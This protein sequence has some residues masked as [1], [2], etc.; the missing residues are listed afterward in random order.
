[1]SGKPTT[2]VIAADALGIARAAALLRAGG[3]VAIPTETVYGL[4]A[5]ADSAEAVARIYAAKGRPDFNPLIVHVAGLAEAAALADMTP[6]MRAFAESHWPGPVTL[7]LPRR[8]DSPLAPAV[9]AGLDTVAIRVPSHPVAR[10]VMAAAGVPLA[11]P[12]A[13]RSGF[14]SPTSADHV[15]A[16][17]DGRIDLVLD[18][19]PTPAG[20]ESTILKMRAGGGW[21][22]LRP[23]PAGDTLWKRA[24]GGDAGG[25][26][27][28]EAPGQLASHYAPGKPVRLDAL[29]AAPDEFM[30]GFGA[31]GGDVSLSAVGD[32]E[33]AARRLYACLHDGARAT[34][35]RIAVAPIPHEGLGLALNNRLRRAAA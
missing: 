28:I 6:E 27:A 26:G 30:I 31:V 5:R 24:A 15:L 11:A 9:S 19:G 22:E 16:T 32:L 1:M 7:V 3:L 34:K 14:V 35:P 29:D 8:A 25:A 12:S 2:P 10:A 20:I 21:E 13:N 23:G 33:E 4:A 18:A 17:L